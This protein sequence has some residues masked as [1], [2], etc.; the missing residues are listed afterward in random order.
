MYPLNSEW[1]LNVNLIGMLWMGF[2]SIL[3]IITIQKRLQLDLV[4]QNKPTFIQTKLHK[5]SFTDS[6]TTAQ[7]FMNVSFQNKF[8][9]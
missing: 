8:K 6:E 4:S 2:D 7:P 3:V 9:V 1:L 5:M